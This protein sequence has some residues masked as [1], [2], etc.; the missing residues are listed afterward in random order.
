MKRIKVCAICLIVLANLTCGQKSKNPQEASKSLKNI[1]IPISLTY[2]G[3]YYINSTGARTENGCEAWATMLG[4]GE[5]IYASRCDET[6]L[7]RLELHVESALNHNKKLKPQRRIPSAENYIMIDYTEIKSQALFG[8]TDNKSYAYIITNDEKDFIYYRAA[9][10]ASQLKEL[11]FLIDELLKSNKSME[12]DSKIVLQNSRLNVVED[13][14]DATQMLVG[15]TNS[16]KTI[17]IVID[18]AGRFL[19]CITESN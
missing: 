5:Y 13:M 14:S 2:D 6:R 11:D 9:G 10:T 3:S 7:E 15:K 18:K 12:S 17:A 1:S 16:G 19:G 4:T 8:V